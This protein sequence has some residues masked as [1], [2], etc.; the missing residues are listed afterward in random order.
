LVPEHCRHDP[1]S[2]QLNVIFSIMGTPTP[3]EVEDQGEDVVQ[4]IA[5]LPVIPRQNFREKFPRADP[6]LID[7]LDQMLRFAPSQRISVEAAIR[8]NAFDSVRDVAAEVCGLHT[9]PIFLDFI[10]N[11]TPPP[12][13]TSP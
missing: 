4:Y 2:D 3:A 12:L 9:A 7:L 10:L 5:S 13:H 11:R 1:Q 8:H 6:Q